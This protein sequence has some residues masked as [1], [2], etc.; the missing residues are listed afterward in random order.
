MIVVKGIFA[1]KDGMRKEPVTVRFS[2]DRIG[3][4]LSLECNGVMI[5]VPFEKIQKLIEKTQIKAEDRK[6][7]IEELI[8]G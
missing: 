3:D 2:S 5:I 1:N 6:K 4:T 8:N 7:M